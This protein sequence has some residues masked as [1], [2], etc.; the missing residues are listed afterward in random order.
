MFREIHKL[1]PGHYALF[2]DGQLR[3]AK[4]WDL[5][6]PPKDYLFLLSEEELAG[7]IRER[8]RR[9][10]QGQMVIDVPVGACLRAGLDSSRSD[11]NKEHIAD[12]PV[13]ASPIT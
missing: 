7:E 9:C 3:I 1:P 8:F 11:A 2:C 6:F 4:Y 13:R 10:V 5:A 12:R